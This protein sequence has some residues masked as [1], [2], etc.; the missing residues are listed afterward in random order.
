MLVML[1]V[2]SWRVR[3]QSGL[4]LDANVVDVVF[5]NV[6]VDALLQ[7]IFAQSFA[8]C[9]TRNITRRKMC[10]CVSRCQSPTTD[11][12]VSHSS[13]THKAS[14]DSDC[15]FPLVKMQSIKTPHVNAHFTFLACEQP[16]TLKG[17]FDPDH[18]EVYECNDPRDYFEEPFGSAATCKGKIQIML[19]DTDFPDDGGSLTYDFPSHVGFEVGPGTGYN[20]FVLQIHSR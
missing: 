14:H 4:A 18:P 3:A 20:F 19:I 6:S 2:G 9:N 10:G 5:P 7:V 12:S 11:L 13:M 17:T 16:I 1:S 15:F 8:F